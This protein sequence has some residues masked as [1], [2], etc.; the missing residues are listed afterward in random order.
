VSVEVPAKLSGKQKDLLNEFGAACDDSNYP[1]L[2]QQR[3]RFAEF[4]EHRR[5]MKK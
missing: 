3:D 2:R 5:A 1:Q 4:Q